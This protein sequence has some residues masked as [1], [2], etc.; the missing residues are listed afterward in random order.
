M[1]ARVI[2]SLRLA[3]KLSEE[4]RLALLAAKFDGCR[5]MLWLPTTEVTEELR[6]LKLARELEGETHV[7]ISGMNVRA[8]VA[9][10]GYPQGTLPNKYLSDAA[11]RQSR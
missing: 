7:T 8:I 1:T 3:A 9:R 4:A 6:G 5:W 11:A 10:S 2:K